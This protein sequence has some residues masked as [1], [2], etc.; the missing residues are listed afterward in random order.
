MSKTKAAS[1]NTQV[2][3]ST[4]VADNSSEGNLVVDDSADPVQQA[5]QQY[6]EYLQAL[7]EPGT[8]PERHWV[9]PPLNP[10]ISD[11]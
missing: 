7:Y 3:T 11:N 4:S 6:Q 8:N 9:L 10:N 2:T 1:A 5:L